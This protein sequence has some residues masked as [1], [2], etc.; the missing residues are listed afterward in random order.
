MTPALLN[1]FRIFYAKDRPLGVVLWAQVNDEV[2]ERLAAGGARL[3]PQ[4]WKSGDQVWAVDVIAPFGGHEEMLKD[5]KAKVHPDREI[6]YLAVGTTSG[7]VR[8]MT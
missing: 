8:S 5:L 6:R 3:R 7:Q 4:D 2:A 1:Q